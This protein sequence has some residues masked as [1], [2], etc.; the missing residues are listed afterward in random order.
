MMR[1][2]PIFFECFEMFRHGIAHIFLPGVWRVLGVEFLHQVVSCDFCDD[3][4]AGDGNGLAVALW[5]GF[6]FLRLDELVL[7]FQDWRMAAVY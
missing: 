7:H 2:E 6:Y 3:R 4:G 5:Y 1:R